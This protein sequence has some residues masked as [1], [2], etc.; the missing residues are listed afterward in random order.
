MSSGNIAM[1]TVA[2]RTLIA[3][4]AWSGFY[5]GNSEVYRLDYHGGLVKP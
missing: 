1:S 5:R 4:A 3:F 2:T